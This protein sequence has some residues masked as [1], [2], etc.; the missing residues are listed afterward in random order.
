MK[1]ISTILVL[2]LSL[3]ILCACATGT[4]TTSSSSPAIDR[5]LKKGELTVGTAA[6]M[7]PFNMTTKNG[8]IIGLEA[9]LARYMADTMG[10]NLKL[11]AIQFSELLPALESGQ[12]DMI[13][14]NMTMTSQRNLKV[15]FVGPY[16]I[17]G[18][19][20]LTNVATLATASDPNVLDQT[21]YKIAALEGSTSAEFVREIMPKAT[22]V[23]T[24]NYDEGVGLVIQGSVHAMVADHPICVIS[25]ARYP[26][27]NLFAII[28]PFTYEPIGVALPANDPLLVNWVT[29]FLNK[30]EDSGVMDNV[31]NRWFK[32]T[33]WVKR[34]P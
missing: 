30:L 16:F 2:I 9:D 15:A 28:A 5:I 23:T 24:K 14:S 3:S 6:M 20:V 8:K 22:L 13:L 11:K 34:L 21:K 32:D 10:V 33:S 1:K 29:N 4:M 18:K 7:P 25:V 17:S 12:I 26:Q 31:R 19:G 27:H